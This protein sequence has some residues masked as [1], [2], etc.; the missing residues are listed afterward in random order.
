VLNANTIETSQHASANE[1]MVWQA[2]VYKH[3]EQIY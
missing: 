1:V 2:E 3:D